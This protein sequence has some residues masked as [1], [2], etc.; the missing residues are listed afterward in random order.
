M[1][2]ECD[3]VKQI[4]GNVTKKKRKEVLKTLNKL[5]DENHGAFAQIASLG[6]EWHEVLGILH[7]AYNGKSTSRSKGAMKLKRIIRGNPTHKRAPAPVDEESLEKERK[8]RDKKRLR[9]LVQDRTFAEVENLVHQ[10]YLRIDR[11]SGLLELCGLASDLII[12]DKCGVLIKRTRYVCE[13]CGDLCRDCQRRHDKG[14]AV[15]AVRL[16]DR[17]PPPLVLGPGDSNEVIWTPALDLKLMDGVELLGVGNWDQVAAYITAETKLAVAG[18]NA[19]TRFI[20]IVTLGEESKKYE[21]TTIRYDDLPHPRPSRFTAPKED[22]D[23]TDWDLA[24][25]DP[26]TLTAEGVRR[27]CGDGAV[28]PPGAPAVGAEDQVTGME[29]EAMVSSSVLCSLALDAGPD[30]SD[31]DDPMTGQQHEDALAV[32]GLLDLS[33]A[34]PPPAEPLPPP[35]FITAT[36]V[37]FPTPAPSVGTPWIAHT[38]ATVLAERNRALAQRN[39]QSRSIPGAVGLP[40]PTYR[41]QSYFPSTGNI[42]QS[43]DTIC[44]DTDM[45]EDLDD[46]ADLDC[47]EVTFGMGS[48]EVVFEVQRQETPWRGVAASIPTARG[49]PSFRKVQHLVL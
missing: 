44:E 27:L 15:K 43:G 26:W 32:S 38:P 3:R 28:W 23:Q 34:R 10:G 29:A 11:E 24:E 39:A 37:V 21:K 36:P 22:P 16:V 4:V 2:E 12:C 33:H 45:N 42:V 19:E 9:A 7:K 1:D 14:H 46:D 31:D 6:P 49:R 35:S 48:T 20:N 30:C 8:R 18:E 40:F 5:L 17:L 25:V 41:A 13:T 47:P